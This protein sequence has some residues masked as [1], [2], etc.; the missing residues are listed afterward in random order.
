MRD[1][2][3]VDAV[4]A[5]DEAA[6]VAR[7][8]ALHFSGALGAQAS[9]GASFE[10]CGLPPPPQA[11]TATVW[12]VDHAHS[13]YWSAWEKDV[14]A[15]PSLWPAGVSSYDE[16][17]PNAVRGLPSFEWVED[18]WHKYEALAK[19]FS[20]SASVAVSAAGCATLNATL[21]AHAVVLYEVAYG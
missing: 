19:L 12:V 2:S 1:A 8:L 4:V 21:A 10:L 11:A 14:A 9:A 3:I 13:T 15:H 17:A 20:H 5:V 7:V 16:T 18:E 6:K